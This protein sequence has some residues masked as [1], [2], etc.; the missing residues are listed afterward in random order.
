M[1]NKQIQIVIN[2]WLPI[3]PSWELYSINECK[4]IINILNKFIKN[5]KNFN[6]IIKNQ[7][8]L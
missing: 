6:S 3:K 8:G 5:Y 4:E 1:E 2:D 7:D